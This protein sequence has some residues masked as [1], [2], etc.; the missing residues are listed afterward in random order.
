MRRDSFTTTTVLLSCAIALTAISSGARAQSDPGPLFLP[1]EKDNDLELAAT[2]TLSAQSHIKK[3]D[4]DFQL[5][6]YES[7]GR[8]RLTDTFEVNPVLGYSF[9]FLDLDTPV[10]TVP[11]ELL[12]LS[13]GAA[14]PIRKFDNGWYLAAAVGVG[15]AGEELFDDTDAY[16]GKATFIV[17][18]DFNETTALLVAINYDGNRTMYPDV[19]LPAVALTKV[20]HQKLTLAVGFPYNTVTYRPVEPLKLEMTA[21][22]GT[23]SA[24]VRY[25]LTQRLQFFGT[26]NAISRGFHIDG[27]ERDDRLFFDQ[28]R[29]ETGVVWKPGTYVGITVA[30]GYMFSQE[31][32]TGWDERET[33]RVYEPADAA[34][35]RAGLVWRP[36]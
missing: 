11:R 20:I 15:Y 17:G 26:F 31:F 19:P 21:T 10:E 4:D 25:N 34:Y 8:Y 29:L 9:L 16:Y 35:I 5:K 6:Q 27:L 28:K 12:D 1:F 14:S 33:E 2:V 7:E 32:S 23:V 13:I 24:D 30:G 3:L 22:I 36:F 18:K